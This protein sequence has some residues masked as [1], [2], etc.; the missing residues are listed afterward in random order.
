MPSRWRYAVR[1]S[2]NCARSWQ[3]STRR[4]PRAVD[5]PQWADGGLVILWASLAIIHS[6]RNWS[7]SI[8]TLFTIR[9]SAFDLADARLLLLFH[10]ESYEAHHIIVQAS[11]TKSRT[12][13]RS[14]D[15]SDLM[16]GTRF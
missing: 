11:C 15:A 3:A 9:R 14:H 7:S 6:F 13:K 8:T 1:E 10:L 4:V 12:F 2:S 16:R 5:I